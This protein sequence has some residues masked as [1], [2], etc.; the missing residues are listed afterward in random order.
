MLNRRIATLLLA[1]VLVAGITLG[2]APA[3]TAAAT[4]TF[5]PASVT[6]DG[7]R[8]LPFR[9]TME[10]AGATV[11]Y[12]ST[13]RS[14]YAELDGVWVWAPVYDVY[15][16]VNGERV[17]LSRAPVVVQDVAYY[18]EDFFDGVFSGWYGWGHSGGNQNN[19]SN[20]AIEGLRFSLSYERGT[21]GRIGLVVK[22]VSGYRKTIMI[23]SG[24]TH[25]IVLKRNGAKVW[26]STDGRVYTQAVQYVTLR[27]GESKTYWTDLPT[28]V[29]GSYGVE[30]YFFGVSYKGVV[31]R[32]TI[33][34]GSYNNP[35]AGNSGS[36]QYSLSYSQGWSSS[37]NPP[38]L[39]LRVKNPTG[40]DV[41][42]SYSQSYEFVVW[43]KDGSVTRKQLPGMKIA[44]GASQ[45]HFVYL[46][47][48]KR[49]SYYAECYLKEGGRTVRTI[50][51]LS[52][53][54]K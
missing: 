30:A 16:V 45:T 22:N 43:G 13:D 5:K 12:N 29:R 2:E 20:R 35:P 37:Q 15:A 51:S 48:L 33:Q 42:S 19:D 26:S 18:P 6:R 1:A 32:T 9:Q 23:P 50:G 40:S 24:K 54:V 10:N 25:E 14:F 38:Q 49:G 7:M 8:M 46:N 27:A 31:A 41:T 52:F 47:G 28:L 21:P 44:A 3:A 17:R 39:V 36:L 34:A 4:A 11:Y 53:T